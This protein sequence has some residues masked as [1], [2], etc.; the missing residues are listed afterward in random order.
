MGIRD[1]LRR[2]VMLAK[3]SPVSASDPR[4]LEIL[5]R[6][7][8]PSP[9]DGFAVNAAPIAPFTWEVRTVLSNVLSNTNRVKFAF[10]WRVNVVG[11]QATIVPVLPLV[12]APLPTP[13]LDDVDVMVDINNTGF[14]TGNDGTTSA[15]GQGGNNFVTL[16]T[17]T[18]QTPRLL[19]LAL[20]G[21]SK[22][23]LGFTFRWKQGP[24]AGPVALFQSAII[25]VAIFCFRRDGELG[26]QTSFGMIGT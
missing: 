13:T 16:S 3:N 25:T 10:P 12:G 4:E 1:T 21:E 19:G 5:E 26:N 14:I 2:F 24:A 15:A 22:P 6:A 17:L 20:E 8:L 18:V 11:L 23:E 7:I 9:Q